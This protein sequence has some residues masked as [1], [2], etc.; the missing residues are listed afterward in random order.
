MKEEIARM[1]SY[2][3]KF[4]S[5]MKEA[6]EIGSKA[7]KEFDTKKVDRVLI[8]GLG[9]SGIGGR[10]CQNLVFD[11]CSAPISL[12]NNYDLPSWANSSTLVIAVSYSGNTEET[13][14]AYNQARQKGCQ[15]ACIT[16]GGSLAKMAKEDGFN[17][18]L[19]PG[20]QPPRTSFGYNASQLFFILEAYGLL[21]DDFS[22]K[23][24]QV[25]DV[26]EKK[27]E[28]IRS[29]AREIADGLADTLPVIYAPSNLE[30]VAIRLRQQINENAKMLCWHHVLPEMNHNELV[31]WA[32]KHPNVGVVFLYSDRDHPKVETRRKLTRDILKKKTNACFEIEAQG[33]S[34]MEQAYYLIHLGDWIS[35][36]LAE[37]RGVDPIEI[38][39]ID[40]L[41]S[42]LSK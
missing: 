26:L 24:K 37:I 16:S 25:A 19:I 42:E 2:I 21:T 17:M 7:A 28:S 29:K 32:D 5:D 39:V 22:G 9:G 15:I 20:G 10:I 33:D 6:F 11:S 36:Y 3:E 34:A 18:V 13:L 23:L 31:G 38:D 35:F 4:P 30:G 14:N 27:S 41:K 12:V 40:Y 1:Q 8:V